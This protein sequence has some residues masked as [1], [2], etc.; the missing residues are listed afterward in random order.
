[1]ISRVF[2]SFILLVMFFAFAG[3]IA[4]YIGDLRAAG[5]GDPYMAMVGPFLILLVC[6]STLFAIGYYL[7][8]GKS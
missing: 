3:S 8:K 2:E 6:G 1:M 5:E 7:V 4:Y